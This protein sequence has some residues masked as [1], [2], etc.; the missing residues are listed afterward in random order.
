MPSGPR[1]EARRDAPRS[2]VAHTYI[3]SHALGLF[4]S[5]LLAGPGC[6]TE[7]DEDSTDDDGAFSIREVEPGE[8]LTVHVRA[9]GYTSADRVVT[10]DDWETRS[11]QVEL[12]P[13]GTTFTFFFGM[14]CHLHLLS[15]C[16]IPPPPPH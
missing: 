6:P 11:L 7:L 9:E 13:V 16:G 5:I 4:L 10:M 1:S 2:H 8:S 14:G 15:S 3:P 12:A